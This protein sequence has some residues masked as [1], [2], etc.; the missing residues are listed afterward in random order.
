MIKMMFCKEDVIL[1]FKRTMFFVFQNTEYAYT[2]KLFESYCSSMYG[3]ELWSLEDDVFQDFCC[4]WRTA[5]R[6]L[7]N[8]PFN[9]HCFLLP[10]Y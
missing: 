1:L 7:L 3:S 2:I 8:V 5:L 4:S 6:R 9:A 10:I